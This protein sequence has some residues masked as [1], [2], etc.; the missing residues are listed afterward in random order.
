M[1]RVRSATALGA[2]MWLVCASA[3]AQSTLQPS[4]WEVDVHGGGVTATTPSKGTFAL[5]SMA[6]LAPGGARPVP[7]WFF[8]DGSSQLNLFPSVRAVGPIASLDGLL[9]SRI[10]EHQS[11][12]NV[13]AR[14]ARRLTP[15]FAAELTLTTVWASCR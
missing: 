13:G 10:V 1:R 15:R 3:A 14:M 2:T 5:P 11:G 4:N 12:K 7:S 6:G 8:G 9:Q